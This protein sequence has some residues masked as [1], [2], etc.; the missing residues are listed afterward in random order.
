MLIIIKYCL[1]TSAM[2]IGLSHI[3]LS[4]SCPYVYIYYRSVLG[5]HPLPGKCPCNCFGCSNGKCPLPGKCPGNVSLDRS[6]DQ[7]NKNAYED[8]GDID[9]LDPFSHSDE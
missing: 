4:S 7:A 8:D 3:W 2:S 6:D 1:T 9:D 5:K